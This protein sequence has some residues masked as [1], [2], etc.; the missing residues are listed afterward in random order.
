VAWFL[1][2]DLDPDVTALRGERRWL[3]DSVERAWDGRTKAGRYQEI[4]RVGLTADAMGGHDGRLAER[5]HAV[6]AILE[7]LWDR[8]YGTPIG[9]YAPTWGDLLLEEIA[10]S[11][12][13]YG[14]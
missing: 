9:D 6:S 8:E 5:V 13:V 4:R 1:R 2:H 11:L 14:D 7:S 10:T 12:A 3:V